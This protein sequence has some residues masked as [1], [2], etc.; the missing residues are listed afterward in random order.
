LDE[1]SVVATDG[2]LPHVVAASSGTLQVPINFNS[3]HYDPA[4]ADFKQGIYGTAPP[5]PAILV[6]TGDGVNVVG[7]PSGQMVQIC[8]DAV[9][10]RDTAQNALGSPPCIPISIRP[11][12]V[13]VQA[14]PTALDLRFSAPI[15]NQ[16]LSNASLFALRL[17]N[18]LIS[19]SCYTLQPNSTTA[20][21]ANS[22]LGASLVFTCPTTAT[23]GTLLVRGTI[24][25]QYGV[26]LGTDT[27]VSFSI[28]P[29]TNN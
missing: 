21:T 29:S 27:S 26:E 24:A 17:D 12:S 23:S 28:P 3:S 25:D 22:S 6:D 19:P 18:A 20:V 5:G 7:L 11:L 10:I 4:G 16:M 13:S 9:A 2:R 8:F 15:P 1:A 14:S